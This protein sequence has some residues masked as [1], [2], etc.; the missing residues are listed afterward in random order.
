MLSTAV[1]GGGPAALSAA[2][3]LARA[4]KKVTVFE[5][6]EIGGDLSRTDKIENYPCYDGA[7]RKLTPTRRHKV[8]AAGG[9]DSY[10]A[11]Q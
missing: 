7:V 5:R 9:S 2:L 1:I 6:G 10:G 3:Y 11:C 4:G 8:K